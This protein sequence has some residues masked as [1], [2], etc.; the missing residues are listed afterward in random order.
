[1]YAVGISSLL[2]KEREDLAQYVLTH[3]R[4]L[5][6][7]LMMILNIKKKLQQSKANVSIKLFSAI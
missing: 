2:S 4:S 3:S 1:M 7:D 6:S 5:L